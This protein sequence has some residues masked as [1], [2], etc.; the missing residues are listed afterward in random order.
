MMLVVSIEAL[1]ALVDHAARAGTEECCGLLVGR[2]DQ[3]EEA[4]P[5]ANIAPDPRRHF[6]ID[7]KALG[8]APRGARAGGPQVIGYSHSHPAGPAAPSA[9]DR[10]LAAG[11]GKVWAI[12]GAG[13]VAFWRDDEDG[14]VSLSYTIEDR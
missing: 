1:Q 12:L 5:A 9:M 14:F 8:A 6:E 3:I 4:R 13:G 10:A 2:D 7:P 11:D